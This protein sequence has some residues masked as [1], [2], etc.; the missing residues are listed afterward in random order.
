MII[1]SDNTATNLVLDRI[2]AD[3]VNDYLDT[4]V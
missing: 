2:T 1:V 3:A 4:S